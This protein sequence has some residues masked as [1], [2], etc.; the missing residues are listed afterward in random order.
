LEKFST[1]D[2]KK[3]G[4]LILEALNKM[5]YAERIQRQSAVTGW[6]DIVG[7]VISNETKALKIDKKTLVVKVQRAAWRQQLIFLKEEILKKI[8]TELGEGVV[9]DIRFI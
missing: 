6:S 9:E 1:N 5:G 3:I 8:E 4:G 2:P 7:E